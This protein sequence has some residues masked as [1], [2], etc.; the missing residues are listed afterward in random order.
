MRIKPPDDPKDLFEDLVG[1]LK[2]AL[3]EDLQAVCLFGS[4]A[5]GRYRKGSSDLNLL[6]V[7]KDGAQAPLGRLLPFCH[8][9]AAANVAIPVVVTPEYLETSADVFPIELMVMASEHVCLYGPDPLTGMQAQPDH[10]RLQL[11][12]ELKGKLMALRTG[13]LAS[14]GKA[15]SLEQ[16]TRQAMSAFTA[17][18]RAYLKLSRDQT[19]GPPAQVYEALAQAGLKVEALTR[20][21]QVR[22]GGHKA[23]AQELAGLV[24]QAVGEVEAICQL[25]DAWQDQ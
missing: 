10:L 22:E 18:F 2:Q 8:K 11:E 4:A 3:A 15:R 19:P 21:E 25:V 17:L 20:L 23:G 14:E 5:A 13:F 9:W 16:L 6:L 7:I 12:R 1:D 24:E